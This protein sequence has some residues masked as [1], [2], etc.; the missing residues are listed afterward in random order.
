MNPSLNAQALYA[1]LQ[2]E[3]MVEWKDPGTKAHT[4][5]K[6]A[7]ARAEADFL[8]LRISYHLEGLKK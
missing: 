6:R 8:K 3:R 5:A 7:A 4:A 1:L 2:A